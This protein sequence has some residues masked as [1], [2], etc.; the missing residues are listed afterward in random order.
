MSMLESCTLG[1]ANNG[2][3]GS[4]RLGLPPYRELG[5]PGLGLPFKSARSYCGLDTEAGGL[6]QSWLRDGDH[7]RSGEPGREY[8]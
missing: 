6:V 1:A 5:V 8:G 3:G 7:G 2:A 4:G